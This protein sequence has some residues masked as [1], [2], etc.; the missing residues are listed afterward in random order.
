M[1]GTSKVFKTSSVR[2]SICGE[3]MVWETALKEMVENIITMARENLFMT[4][5]LTAV[6]FGFKCKG[7][8][9]LLIANNTLLPKT[10][11]YRKFFDEVC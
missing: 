5:D 3:L 7:F 9:F 11:S 4:D 10:L 8:Y 1:P 2:E 6:F